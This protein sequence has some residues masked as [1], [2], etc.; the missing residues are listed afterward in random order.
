MPDEITLHNLLRERSICLWLVQQSRYFG[1]FAA[2]PDRGE[3]VFF[4]NRPA[5]KKKQPVALQPG[6]GVK[7]RC[8]AHGVRGDC[9]HAETMDA[10]FPLVD[11]LRPGRFVSKKFAVKRR[12]R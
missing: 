10:K 8:D 4:Q 2:L 1:R 7:Q 5:G 6:A 9:Q 12:L 11:F 3:R